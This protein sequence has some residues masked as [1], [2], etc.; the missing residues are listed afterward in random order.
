MGIVVE[1]TT[2]LRG[3]YLQCQRALRRTEAQQQRSAC[4]EVIGNEKA[5]LALRASSP[6]NGP[7]VDPAITPKYL[8]VPVHKSVEGKSRLYKSCDAALG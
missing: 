2:E 8:Y 6:G 4:T 7:V 1:I 3:W 5:T